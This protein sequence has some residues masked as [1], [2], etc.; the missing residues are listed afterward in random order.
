[1]QR[2]PA[3]S[4]TVSSKGVDW[5]D[6][7]DHVP[8]CHL[9]SIRYQKDFEGTMAP[10]VARMPPSEDNILIREGTVNSTNRSPLPVSPLTATSSGKD[11]K[12]RNREGIWRSSFESPNYTIQYTANMT[13]GGFLERR[14][15]LSLLQRGSKC[16]Q[17][18]ALPGN[19]LI[20]CANWCKKSRI[21]GNV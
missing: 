20:R 14:S 15:R 16:V 17:R 10:P 6:L 3:R 9:E 19:D 2:R 5:S 21:Y 12:G 1:M 8:R 13:S 11:T 4:R 18:K 7:K